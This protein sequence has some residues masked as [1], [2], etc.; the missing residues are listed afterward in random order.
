MDA[1]W[2]DGRLIAVLCAYD[3]GYVVTADITDPYNMVILDSIPVG[4]KAIYTIIVGDYAL[5]HCRGDGCLYSIRIHDRH[6]LS[7]ADIE[8][9][10]G[11]G[12]FDIDDQANYA[13]AL[14]PVLQPFAPNRVRLAV[15]IDGVGEHNAHALMQDAAT[16]RV[17][18]LYATAEPAARRE[19]A[20]AGLLPVYRRKLA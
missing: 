17:D 11:Y 3:G 5:V 19:I 20:L 4:N 12:A 10:G 2:R 7:I 14:V 15:S 18:T 6:N 8:Y 9:A 13:Y 16:W 1:Q